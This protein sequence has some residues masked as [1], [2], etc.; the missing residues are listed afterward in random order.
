[1]P[2]RVGLEQA[3]ATVMA[4]VLAIISAMEPRRTSDG[5][6]LGTGDDMGW[7]PGGG[8]RSSL[9][10]P[11]G[12]GERLLDD[13]PLI[14]E[15]EQGQG[16]GPEPGSTG[17]PAFLQRSP[18][19]ADNG[20]REPFPGD[21]SHLPDDV[22]AGLPIGPGRDT[23]RVL[24]AIC[25]YLLS[26][27]G[28]WRAARPMREHR[29]TA[30][31]P[32]APLP[33]NKQRRLCLVDEH[34]ACPAYTAAQERRAAA[35]AEVGITEVALAARQSRPL[36]R[37]V[38]VALD[39]P[40]AVP[41]SASLIANYRRLTQVGLAALM[42]LAAAVLILARF[43]GGDDGGTAAVSPT[44]TI[45]TTPAPTSMS[46]EPSPTEGT[47][48]SPQATEE[49]SPTNRVRRRYT[50][51]PGDTLTSIAE[52]FNTT[53]ARLQRLNDIEDPSA[54]EPGQVLLIR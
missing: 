51:R 2:I 13:D 25:P 30:V 39:R 31:R 19:G 12:P 21:E 53:V 6:A 44:P 22:A 23:Q 18:F 1:V 45:A 11:D 32:P 15:E 52:R 27:D 4:R 33:L 14:D 10:D 29:C 38:P 46:P 49:A 9:R 35:L 36:T 5:A 50:V 26:D 28:A 7:R 20:D 37:T 47:S 3:Q 42:L 43:T 41:G 8:S 24:A 54:I 17:T 16:E 34:R 40:T 48:A